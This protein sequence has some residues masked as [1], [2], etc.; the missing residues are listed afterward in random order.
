MSKISILDG[1]F[2]DDD[3][4]VVRKAPPKRKGP[5]QQRDH[6]SDSEEDLFP[7]VSPAKRAKQ[8]S[9]PGFSADSLDTFVQ[10]CK[11]TIPVLNATVD[12]DFLYEDSEDDMFSDSSKWKKN[13]SKR[14][15]H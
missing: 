7:H 6:G 14:S 9:K 4:V 13:P 2:D 3:D 8:T 11:V 1:L 5:S 15:G 10:E 12:E